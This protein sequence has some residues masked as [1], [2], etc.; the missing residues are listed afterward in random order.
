[1]LSVIITH[2][3]P[4]FYS[5]FFSPVGNF[6]SKICSVEDFH[7]EECLNPI[8]GY[9]FS[10]CFGIYLDVSLENT[11]GVALTP[12]PDHLKCDL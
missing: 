9:F 5:T 11:L 4:D 8:N 12:M 2:P 1:M 6:I 7:I 10:V 3:Y